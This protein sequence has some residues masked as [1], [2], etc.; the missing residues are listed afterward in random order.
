MCKCKCKC[1]S[2]KRKCPCGFLKSQKGTVCLM[3][4]IAAALYTLG[5]LLTDRSKEPSAL[6]K[7]FFVSSAGFMVGQFIAALLIPANSKNN[8]EE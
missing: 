3:S 7:R 2:E 1:N 8:T 6:I 5:S 4:I